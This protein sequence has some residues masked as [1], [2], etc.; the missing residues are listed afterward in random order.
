MNEQEAT[1]A[2]AQKICPLLSQGSLAAGGVVVRCVGSECQM[3]QVYYGPTGPNAPF[4]FRC[5][6]TTS[7]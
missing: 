6:L 5:G 7:Q 4:P 2:A 3:F 1:A